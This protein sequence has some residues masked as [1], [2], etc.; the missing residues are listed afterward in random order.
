MEV[1]VLGFEFQV[2]TVWI[3]FVSLYRDGAVYNLAEFEHASENLDIH[4]LEAG[5]LV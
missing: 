3:S 5:M 1:L 4:I 2:C